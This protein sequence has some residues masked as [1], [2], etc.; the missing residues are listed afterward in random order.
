MVPP[1]RSDVGR[2]TDQ[3]I[4]EALRHAVQQAP[5]PFI[6]TRGPAHTL[7]YANSAFR[8]LAGPAVGDAL[9]IPVASVLPDPEGS[10]LGTILDRATRDRVEL[11]DERLELPGERRSEWLCNV[12]P[13]IANDG[14]VEALGLEFRINPPDD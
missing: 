12:W 10:A 6:V 11:L 1:P 9:G 2:A 14:R 3:S 13:V 7:V 8:H 5:R 4:Q